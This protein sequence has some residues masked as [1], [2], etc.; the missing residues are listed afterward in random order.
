MTAVCTR[1]VPAGKQS[2]AENAGGAPAISGPFRSPRYLPVGT[3]VPCGLTHVLWDVPEQ[4]ADCFQRAVLF[5][6]SSIMLQ[7]KRPR[8]TDSETVRAPGPWRILTQELPH[9]PFHTHSHI[10]QR[11]LH[12]FIGRAFVLY[13]NDFQLCDQSLRNAQGKR[14]IIVSHGTASIQS[15]IKSIS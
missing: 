10:F 8:C 9:A 6:N 3:A 1:A 12:L 5:M 13:R 14:C 15:D 4:S 7:N 11:I 2:G